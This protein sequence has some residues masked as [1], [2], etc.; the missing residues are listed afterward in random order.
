[1]IIGLTG[2]IAMGKSA[3][4]KMF[5]DLGYPVFD[6][7]A[8]VHKL[9][10]KGGLAVDDI[11]ALF[12][13][14]VVDGAVDRNELVRLIAGNQKILKQLE[15][16]VHPHIT[17]ATK[18][19]IKKEKGAGASIVVID[20]PMLLESGGQSLVDKIMVVS[21]PADIQNIRAMQRPNMTEEKLQLILSHQMPD[22]E[23]R[24]RADYV[25]DSSISL[26]NAFQ[27]IVKI[28]EKLDP[29]FIPMENPYA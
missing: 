6:A 10:D 1:M 8:T 17:A 28:I 21:A 11:S 16:I 5:A 4:A 18:Q 14:A 22:E 29:N 13:T 24:Q 25:I 27:Q 3:T 19:F 15:S 9:Y 23:K 20:N 2:S 12:P 26:A 7:D